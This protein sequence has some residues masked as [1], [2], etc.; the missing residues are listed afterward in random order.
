MTADLPTDLL[1]T[2]IFPM[3]RHIHLHLHNDLM[4]FAKTCRLLREYLRQVSP[5]F[6]KSTKIPIGKC[7][8]RDE[9]GDREGGGKGSSSSA[10]SNTCKPWNEFRTMGFDQ[11]LPLHFSIQFLRRM[12]ISCIHQTSTTDSSKN[13]RSQRHQESHEVTLTTTL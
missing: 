11:T 2:Q 12:E 7:R 6:H 10:V 8:R 3:L 9:A 13:S 5:L 1:L 4:L